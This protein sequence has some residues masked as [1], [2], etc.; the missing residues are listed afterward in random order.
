MI[1]EHLQVERLETSASARLADARETLDR[2][3]AL[4]AAASFGEI[5]LAFD[6]IRR[7]LD[8]LRGP[9]GLFS[10]VHP[11][12]A[13]REAARQA[14]Q[15]V[16]SFDTELSLDRRVFERLARLDPASAP[17]PTEARLLEHVLRDYRRSGVDRDEPTRVRIRELNE[18][19]VKIGQE[20]DQNIARD[21]RSI[22]IPEGRAALEGLPADYVAS[23]PE[24]EHGAVTITTDMPDYQPFMTYARRGDLR[25]R[26][27]VEHANRAVP[28]NLDVL[29]RLIET[30]H[31][32]ATL[33]G[34]PSWADYV[35]E[36]KMVKTAGAAR[37]FIERVAE[38]ARPR[39]E[40]EYRELLEAKRELEPEA[41]RVHD[42]ERSYL[43][44]RVRASRFGFESQSVRPY[45][46]YASV[47]DGVLAT[48]A[49]LYGV[50]FRRV[51]AEVWHP[52]VECHEVFDARREG[53]IARFYLDMHPRPDKYKHAAMFHLRTGIEGECLPEAALVCNFPSPSADDPALL[54]H[55]DVT[56]F[57][58]EFG[59]LL[60][61]LFAGRQRYLWFSGIST[62]WDFV[63]APSQ[64]FEEWAWDS[65]VLGRF[66]RHFRTGEPLPA[67]ILAR[68]RA[69]EEYGKGLQIAVQMFYASLSIS[70]YDEDPAALDLDGRLAELKRKLT[71][72]PHE[73][74]T[75]FQASFGH[76][77]G[78]SAIYYTYMWSLVIAKDL[79][80][81]F[82]GGL[83]DPE[84]AARYRRAVLEP[85]GSKDAAELVRDFLGRE[86]AFEAWEAWLN[87]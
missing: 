34:Y 87:R 52:T 71:P 61:H 15:R 56:T 44:E 84:L 14:E 28:Q 59:H 9:I 62:E 54:Q 38:R 36:D 16:A 48:S 80:S 49:A 82:E 20:F 85:G 32:L 43:V 78:Y 45:F 76:L 19:L 17:G 81:R 21:T 11:D 24:D 64:M 10:Q 75:H 74:G 22:T 5:L 23:H 72:F 29:K 47:R 40:Q 63:E 77:H 51:E 6:R 50:E 73:P 58:H 65:G 1:E 35:T 69:A 31:E 27:Y 60:H 86:Y 4:P 39:M 70:Y 18:E 26:L 12:A 33:L 8:R 83:M 42:W 55:R 57:F 66:A 53:R 13:V 67:E 41:E 7:P 30:R 37:E 68:M 3:L 2:F 46:P 79:F 25:R